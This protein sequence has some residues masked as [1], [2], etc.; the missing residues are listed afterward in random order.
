MCIRDRPTNWATNCPEI[1]AEVSKRCDGK[2]EHV[3]T[4]GGVIKQAEIYS[5][6]LVRAILRGIS[7]CLIK[8][9]VATALYEP[10]LIQFKQEPDAL[11]PLTIRGAWDIQKGLENRFGIGCDDHG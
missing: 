5:P 3:K 7:R 11:P 9:R 6:I 4:L 10:W 8:Y 2:H 1:G